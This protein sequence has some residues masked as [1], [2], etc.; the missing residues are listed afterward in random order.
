MEVYD[1]TSFIANRDKKIKQIKTDAQNLNSIATEINV[2][3]HQH[4]QK[5]DSIDKELVY[6][7]EELNKANKDLEKAAEL[8]KGGNKCFIWILLFLAVIVGLLLFFMLK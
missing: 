2:K 7:V 6:N 5:L 4:D 3:V 1:Q 8:T